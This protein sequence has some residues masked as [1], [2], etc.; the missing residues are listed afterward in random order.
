MMAYRVT[1]RFEAGKGRQSF[2]REV[3]AASANHAE[4]KV[5]AELT[6]E[7]GISRANV[8]IDAVEEA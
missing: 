6:S 5:Y 3:D 4:D 7:H 8:E 2:E 1:G